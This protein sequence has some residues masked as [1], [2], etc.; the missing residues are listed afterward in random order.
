VG[1]CANTLESGRNNA[2]DGDDL[3]EM[4]DRMAASMSASPA[5]NSA[6][7]AEGAL[8]VVVQPVENR[9]TGEVLPRGPAE[10]FTARVRSLLSK[11]A[12]SRFTW[13]M[14]R[15]SFY[16]LRE[17]QSDDLG[18]SPDS[19]QPR[20]ALTAIFSTL[21]KDSQKDQSV[22]YLCTFELTNLENRQVLWSDKHEVK[23]RVV[24]EF[25]D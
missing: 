24:K 14:N 23:K 20:Y 7:L 4:T 12:A 2:L 18:P 3:V 15:D 9:M 21:R 6:I 25:L 10:A 19:I 22:Y 5:I 1:G 11:H 8:R 16:R 17:R 13:I